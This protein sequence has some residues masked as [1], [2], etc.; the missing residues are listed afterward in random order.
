MSQEN[1]RAVLAKRIAIR[2]AARRLMHR[3]GARA[4]RRDKRVEMEPQKLYTNGDY[5]IAS[6]VCGDSAIQPGRSITSPRTSGSCCISMT[7]SMMRINAR[8]I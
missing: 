5:W 8:T 3:Y 7:S 2:G 4:A 6:N 1:S